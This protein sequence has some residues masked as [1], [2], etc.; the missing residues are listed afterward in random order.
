MKF[1]G[2]GHK[3]EH[4]NPRVPIELARGRNYYISSFVVGTAT[5]G[6][7]YESLSKISSGNQLE[8]LVGGML[9]LATMVGAI[10]TAGCLQS[11]EDHRSEAQRINDEL[12]EY[13]QNH[14]EE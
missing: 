5:V 7:G 12:R 9:G 3:P 10:A 4:I 2:F 11:A 14:S 13:W 6:T 1:P 8:M